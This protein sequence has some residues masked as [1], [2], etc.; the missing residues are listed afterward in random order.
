M[1]YSFK[2]I[3]LV[4]IILMKFIPKISLK[5]KIF[6]L[7]VFFGVNGTVIFKCFVYHFKLHDFISLTFSYLFR[8]VTKQAYSKHTRWPY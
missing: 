4:F 2:Y 1:F 6:V 5:R 7:E 3:K 8:N